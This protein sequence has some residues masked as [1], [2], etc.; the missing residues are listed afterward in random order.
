MVTNRNASTTNRGICGGAW[1]RLNG[2]I[3]DIIVTSRA[4]KSNAFMGCYV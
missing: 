3:D 1:E 4:K 2:D